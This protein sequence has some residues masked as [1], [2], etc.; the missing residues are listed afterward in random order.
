MPA[1][2]R[3]LSAAPSVR[4]VAIADT[5]SRHWGLVLVAGC[6]TGWVVI[7]GAAKLLLALI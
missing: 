3:R 6:A 5:P 1:T 4:A 2:K 7:L